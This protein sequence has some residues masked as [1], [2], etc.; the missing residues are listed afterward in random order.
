MLRRPGP[1][2]VLALAC[3]CAF[4]VTGLLAKLV[5]LTQ[6]RDLQTLDGFLGLGRTSAQ[7]VFERIIHLADP[8]PYALVGL[9]LALVALV[10]GRRRTALAIPLVFAVSATSAELLKRV[11]AAPRGEDWLEPARHIGGA[12]WPSGHSTAVMTMALCA[13]LAAPP[14]WRPTVAALGGVLAIAVAFSI[15]ALGAH[16]PSDVFGGYLLAGT[17]T[18]LTLAGLAAWEQRR[19]SSRRAEP[20]VRR[21]D[22]LPAVG[23]A[24]AVG[25]A[26][27]ALAITRPHA[28]LGYAQDHT[29][30][31]AGAL[32]IAALA[33]AL[34]T[35]TAAGLLR[36]A[37]AGWRPAATAAPRRRW[38]RG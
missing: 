8:G 29:S 10:R 25:V 27:V 37:A 19:P 28:L 3:A 2:L 1:P 26:A 7:P 6:D 14:R 35:T 36:P 15:L 11:L 24:L 4:A 33:V 12:S 17:Y 32:V 5:P 30:F 16:F 13:V 34:A 38:R 23:V 21:V 18:M 20:A 31:V 9:A 22:L